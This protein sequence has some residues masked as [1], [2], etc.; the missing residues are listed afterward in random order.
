[1]GFLLGLVVGRV[2]I[3][4]ATLQAGLHDG[5]VLI[6]EGDV[7]ADV[8]FVAVEELHELLDGI[9]VNLVGDDAASYLLGDP[10]TL[11]FRARGEDYFGEDIAV[12]RAFVSHDGTNASGSDNKYFSHFVLVILGFGF[13][14]S[15]TQTYGMLQR[16]GSFAKIRNLSDIFTNFAHKI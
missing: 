14:L 6:R 3:V 2:E 15:E 1:M 13:Y 8:G 16:F 11:R 4:D 10:V 5:E 9:C 12:L 7:D